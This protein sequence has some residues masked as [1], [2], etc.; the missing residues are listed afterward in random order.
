[1]LESLEPR[2]HVRNLHESGVPRLFS[3]IQ[4]GVVDE[5]RVLAVLAGLPDSGVAGLATLYAEVPVRYVLRRY[6][7]LLPLDCLPL[8][9]HFEVTQDGHQQEE[10]DEAHAAADYQTQPP[11]QEAADTANVAHGRAVAADYRV[12]RVQRLHLSA[13]AS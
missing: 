10:D 8:L 5:V 13:T 11:R 12:R 6:R 2:S 9:L 4:R 7:L 1:M 3:Y